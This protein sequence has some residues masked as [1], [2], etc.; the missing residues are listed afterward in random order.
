MSSPK[1]SVG[2]ESERDRERDRE[3]ERERGGSRYGYI[4]EAVEHRVTCISL[5]TP[6]YDIAVNMFI[7]NLKQVNKMTC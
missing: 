3:I 4:A 7:D 1:Y 2:D 5:F 6:S